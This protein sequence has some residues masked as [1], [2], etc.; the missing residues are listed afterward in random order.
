MTTIFYVHDRTVEFLKTVVWLSSTI[1]QVNS[2]A[3]QPRGCSFHFEHLQI[4]FYCLVTL[5][6][7]Y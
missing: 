4:I 2:E 7:A 5:D 3:F 6:N 1:K